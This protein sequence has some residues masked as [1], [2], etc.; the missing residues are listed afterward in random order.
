MLSPFHL[1]EQVLIQQVGDDTVMGI[2]VY[3]VRLTTIKEQR[4][5]T[6]PLK[7][8]NALITEVVP[9]KSQADRGGE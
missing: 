7:K 3:A 6:I 4:N 8:M 9:S 5:I 2:R 1:I